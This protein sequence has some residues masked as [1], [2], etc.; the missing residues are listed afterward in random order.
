[1]DSAVTAMTE[2]SEEFWVEFAYSSVCVCVCVCVC[3]LS[4][5]GQHTMTFQ[6][7][8]WGIRVSMWSLTY[9]A[10][11]KGMNEWPLAVCAAVSQQRFVSGPRVLYRRSTYTP[12][13]ATVT[14]CTLNRSGGGTCLPNTY[15]FLLASSKAILTA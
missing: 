7:Y 10:P 9:L 13:W 8:L 6:G 1:M 11:V 3:V 15:L 12:V 2:T 4:D 5:P 14:C